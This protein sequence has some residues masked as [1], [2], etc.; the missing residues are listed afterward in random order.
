M[1]G[2]SLYAERVS[3]KRQVLPSGRALCRFARQAVR[4][5]PP[6]PGTAICGSADTTGCSVATRPCSDVEAVLASDLADLCFTDPPYNVNY[7]NGSDKKRGSKK[8]PI[9][10]DALG[11]KFG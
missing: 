8:R 7:A 3:L 11:E 1:A 4:P 5:E 2:S 10:N 6:V 9:L